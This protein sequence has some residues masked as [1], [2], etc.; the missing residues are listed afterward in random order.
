MGRWLVP[1][2]HGA[3]HDVVGLERPGSAPAGLDC[4]EVDLRDRDAVAAALRK[5]RPARIVHLAAL[6][7]PSDAA[8]D[9][10]E[11]ERVNDLAVGHLLAAI[12]RHAPRARLLHIG[13]GDVYGLQTLEDT[14]FREDAPLRPENAYAATKAAGE[15]RVE[16]A[17]ERDGIHAVRARPFNHTGP[18]RPAAYA[19]ASF[20]RQIALIERGASEPVLHV[21]NL[22]SVRDYS[23][24]RDVVDAYLL[25]LERG[26]SG[27]AYNVC[28]GRGHSL[29]ELVERLIAFSDATP[30]II[31]DLERFRPTTGERVAAVGD[32][33]RLRALGWVPRYDFDQTLRDV[34][35]DWRKR[36]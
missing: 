36:A 1:A 20:A 5:T 28:S 12:A 6:A 2:L 25:L 16:R 8:R 19:E 4:L 7:A 29:S 3:G 30:S 15:R 27:A 31:V 35:E 10:L 21:G 26:E 32:P 17:C 9:P 24:V 22:E 14:P 23:D 34:L 18:G 11:A 13:T 33:A